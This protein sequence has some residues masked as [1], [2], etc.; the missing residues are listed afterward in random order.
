[1][2]QCFCIHY[3]ICLGTI[4]SLNDLKDFRQWGSITPGHPEYGVTPGVETTTGPLGQGFCQWGLAWRLLRLIW[5]QDLI[6]RNYKLFDHYI[7]AIVTD[8]DLMEGVSSEAASLA[9][10]L[11]LG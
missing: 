2:A 9:G 7:Y 6:K 11:Q 1:M 5:R 4:F 8:G 10:H 3:C